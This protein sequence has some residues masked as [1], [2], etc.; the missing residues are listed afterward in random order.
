MAPEPFAIDVSPDGRAIVVTHQTSNNV[1][2][3][4]QDWSNDRGPEL[5]YDLSGLGNRP[6][7]VAA[8][9]PPASVT[10]RLALAGGSEQPN[11]GFLVTFRLASQ[12]SLVRYIPESQAAPLRPYL[13]PAG[14]API[15]ASSNGEDS[16]GIAVD[17]S[18]RRAAEA[19][20][21]A[22]FGAG[23]EGD[24]A[25]SR[26]Q[27]ASLLECLDE[28][29]AYGLDVYVAGRSPETLLIGR[30]IPEVNALSSAELPTFYDSVSL[31]LGV[32]RVV[33]GSVIGGEDSS[34]LVRERRVFVVCFDSR[35]V[36]VYDPLR[37]TIDI[38]LVT[39]R[40][41]HPLAIDEQHGLLFVGHF[42]DSYVGVMSLD[43][44]FPRTYGTMVGT[45]GSPTPPRASK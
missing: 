5:D 31:P 13:A 24:G 39:G 16:R 22:D 40:G 2:L 4:T 37:R 20:C 32:S 35:R 27:R 34:G 9:P 23:C 1:A 33:V 41:P 14:V 29:A 38:E 44:R 19:R 42:T 28:A 11:Y 10:E 8:L 18:A 3:F 6:V 25:D 26:A 12:V 36:I 45:I 30:T 15:L 21:F 43:R 7:G 17:D